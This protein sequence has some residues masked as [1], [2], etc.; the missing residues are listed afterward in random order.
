LSTSGRGTATDANGRY[1]LTVNESDSIY[2]SYLNKGTIR[3]AVK[4]IPNRDAFE[5]A[6]HVPVSELKT[7]TVIPKNY[8]LDSL[9]NRQAYAKVFDFQKP[10]LKLT[11]PNYTDGMGVGVDLDELIN[12]FRFKRTRR[13][14]SFQRRLL[15][16]EQDKFVDHRFNRTIVKK[17]TGLGGTALDTFMIRYRPSVDFTREASEYDFLAYI[18]LAGSV[19]TKYYLKREPARKQD[20]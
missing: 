12:V 13:I 10:G 11:T 6:L 1:S 7:V 9:E 17:L 8:R 18:R 4:D 2:F 15:Q 19:Y 3:Y 5:I 16:E 20:E 14:Q